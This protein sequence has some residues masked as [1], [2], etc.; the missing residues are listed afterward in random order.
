MDNTF[1]SLFY[2]RGK[3]IA[4]V[5]ESGVTDIA[6]PLVAACVVLP[7]IDVRKDDL[8]IFDVN[9]S[10]EVP[11]RRR[12]VLAEVIYNNAL[13]IGIGLVDPTEID[14]LGRQRSINL[15]MKRAVLNCKTQ[16][17]GEK[18]HPDFA[19][20]DGIEKIKI[21]I[22]QEAV[23][24]GDN[25]S[26]AVAAASIVAKV[27]RDSIMAE[28]HTKY[29]YYDW[30]SN[31]GFPCENHYEGIDKHGIVFG[32]HRLNSWPIVPKKKEPNPKGWQSRR[33]KWRIAT[34]TIA[35]K[36]QKENFYG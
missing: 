10:K 6:G 28:L 36:N 19:I 7:K 14:Y 8:A 12:K 33:K 30:I 35:S 17:D 3:L 23:K 13:G 24:G 18:V 34:E 31:K 15:A 21:Q 9:D 11:D 32:V 22:P 5:D 20:V 25:K 2:N 26:L 4:G 1:D 29:P 27:Y 16:G